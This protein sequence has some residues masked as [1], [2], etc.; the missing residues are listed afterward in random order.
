MF[1]VTAESLEA[2]DV[3]RG[4]LCGHHRC[5][6]YRRVPFRRLCGDGNEF[7]LPKMLVNTSEVFKTSEVS[8]RMHPDR[9][10][11]PCQGWPK[12]D[13]GQYHVT[14]LCPSDFYF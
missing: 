8:L 6:E 2:K 12:Y 11:N 9:V 7:F 14:P 10:S 5:F 13:I 1:K 3:R 4:G